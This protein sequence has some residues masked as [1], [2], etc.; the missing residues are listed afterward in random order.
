MLEI[1]NPQLD[2][3]G[4]MLSRPS[5]ETEYVHL[6]TADPLPVPDYVLGIRAVRLFNKLAAVV[7]EECGEKHEGRVFAELLCHSAVKI[8]Q[9]CAGIKNVLHCPALIEQAS[10][11][12]KRSICAKK[13]GE[14]FGKFVAIEIFNDVGEQ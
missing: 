3:S 5:C 11:T 7:D 1:N 14:G 4:I 13:T 9:F 6:A 8:G 12:V 10:E 2:K